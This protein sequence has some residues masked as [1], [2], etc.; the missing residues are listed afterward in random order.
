MPAN[1]QVGPSGAIGAST[2]A[3]CKALDRRNL[4]GYGEAG[5]IAGNLAMLGSS[6]ANAPAVAL[7]L[8]SGNASGAG[9][10]LLPTAFAAGVCVVSAVPNALTK[11]VA[12]AAGT[13]AAKAVS[14]ATMPGQAVA[15]SM[16]SLVASGAT[17][18][19]D[20]A[21]GLAAGTAVV[22][23]VGS[24]PAG[25]AALVQASGSARGDT[26]HPRWVQTVFGTGASPSSTSITIGAGSAIVVHVLDYSGASKAIAVAEGASA[27]TLATP[28]GQSSDVLS[29][30]TVAT[31]YKLG[32]T[33]GA[34]TIT[35]SA[36]LGDTLYYAISEYA[37]VTRFDVSGG[38]WQH[39]PGAG[40]NA[41]GSGSLSPAAGELVIG[42]CWTGSGGASIPG[43][44]SGAAR[45]SNS[46][47]AVS[48]LITDVIAAGGSMATTFTDANGA[49][50]NYQS[51]ALALSP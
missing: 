1:Y 45:A 13:A 6:K 42:A 49:L 39:T 46:F 12:S 4:C 16:G 38:Q 24:S 33:A 50:H 29:L 10:A 30:D 14:V 47:G 9:F 17:S 23:A 15:L 41:I 51:T 37:G 26:G 20:S 21:A 43:S 32:M 7:A 35:V 3:N 18:S 40:V 31:F 44:S 11:A 5:F 22:Q 19:T 2:R 28:P 48:L 34:H 36:S 25:T 8:A 27:F